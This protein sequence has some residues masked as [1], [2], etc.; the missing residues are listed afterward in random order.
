MNKSTPLAHLPR[1]D[2]AA[3]ETVADRET[4]RSQ[5]AYDDEDDAIV[6]EVRGNLGIAIPSILAVRQ[7]AVESADTRDRDWDRTETTLAVEDAVEEDFL[8]ADVA[9]TVP[10]EARDDRS[11]PEDAPGPPTDVVAPKTEREAQLVPI[12]PAIKQA[13][14]LRRPYAIACSSLIVAGVAFTL[15][16]VVTRA[17]VERVLGALA[18]WSGAPVLARATVLATVVAATHAAASISWYT[19]ASCSRTSES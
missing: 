8:D 19:R 14:P 2:A 4:L 11:V 9:V 17:P 6:H 10:E 1:F 5:A 3:S 15:F 13:C 7:A 18:S 12:A 16:I